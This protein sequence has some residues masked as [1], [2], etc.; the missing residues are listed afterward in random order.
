MPS[1]WLVGFFVG[2]LITEAAWAQDSDWGDEPWDDPQAGTPSVYAGAVAGVQ[3]SDGGAG[4]F[5]HSSGYVAGGQLGVAFASWRLESEIV[6]QQTDY[7]DA[8]D[9]SFD[10][11]VVRGALGLYYD[12]EP[13]AALSGLA[14]YLGGGLGVASLEVSGTDGNAFEDETTSFTLHGELGLNLPLT[15]NVVVAPH[16]RFEWFDSGGE[17]EGSDDDFYAHAVRIAVR[18]LF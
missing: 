7:E 14:P 13:I 4:A 6:Y 3:F 8:V 10:L 18:F 5:D 11:E 2:C 15:E 1:K 9:A 12:V 16:Y 17:T